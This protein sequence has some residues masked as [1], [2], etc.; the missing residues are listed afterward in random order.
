[1]IA[2]NSGGTGCGLGSWLEVRRVPASGWFEVC[3]AQEQC[4]VLVTHW[5]GGRTRACGGQDCP[6][7]GSFKLRTYAFFGVNVMGRDGIASKCVLE[8]PYRFAVS[9]RL[10]LGD[11]K[12]AVGRVLRFTRR[13]SGRRGRLEEELR[14][15]VLEREIRK[16]GIDEIYCS[17]AGVL[18]LEVRA[19]QMRNA[20]D[21][22]R[23]FLAACRAQA[24]DVASAL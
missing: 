12:A 4:L 24:A 18:G 15:V 19:E 17:V 8:L 14:G 3:V 16:V 13:G 10:W 20:W 2:C 22:A 1:M 21:R 23:L 5:V 9:S 7:C 6:L 11:A